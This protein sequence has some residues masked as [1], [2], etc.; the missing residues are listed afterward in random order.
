MMKAEE[1]KNSILQMAMQGKLVPQDPNDEPA[2]TLLERIKEEKEQLIKNKIIKRNNKESTIWKEEGHWY[3]KIGKNGET[4][5]IEEEIPFE[6]PYNWSWCSLEKLLYIITGISYKKGDVTSEGIRILRGG[7]IQNDKI[8]FLDDDVY[9][10][11]KYFNE[12]KE[13]K[14][15]DIIIVASTGSKKVILRR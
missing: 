3:E 10:P 12:N 9:L 6:I 13:L 15:Y 4:K 8:Y 14:K 7:N 5:C 2:S 1:L 11:M